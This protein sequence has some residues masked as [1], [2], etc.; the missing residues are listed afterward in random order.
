MSSC[1]QLLDRPHAHEHLVQ[2]YGDD[3]ETLA[4]NV[5]RFLS[6]GWRNGE[7]CSSSRPRRIASC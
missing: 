5:S 6:E 2:L 1:S 3:H 4:R 7:G